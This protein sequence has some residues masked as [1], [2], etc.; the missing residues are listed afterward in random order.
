MR[1]HYTT[2]NMLSSYFCSI[3]LTHVTFELIFLSKI[4]QR[5]FLP[6][7]VW[8]QGELMQ[9]TVE[10]PLTSL[11]YRLLPAKF[12]KCRL[13]SRLLIH[14]SNP[15]RIVCAL[16]NLYRT[17]WKQGWQHQVGFINLVLINKANLQTKYQDT[18][19]NMYKA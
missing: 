9:Y 13:I 19:V 2:Q 12:C 6:W 10:M 14:S 15:C 18:C 17:F 1:V 11:S 8:L 7:G 3:P 4:S 5:W 16:S